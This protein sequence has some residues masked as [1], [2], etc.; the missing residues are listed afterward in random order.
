[1]RLGEVDGQ[2]DLAITLHQRDCERAD[3]DANE[4]NSGNAEWIQSFVAIGVRRVSDT[5]TTPADAAVNEL[6]ACIQAALMADP[7]LSGVDVSPGTV[8]DTQ[9]RSIEPIEPTDGA[10]A[11]WECVF[12]LRPVFPYNCGTVAWL[13][14][15]TTPFT[16]LDDTGAYL[17]D[18]TGAVLSTV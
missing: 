8:I 4:S 10:Y 6:A 16:L 17:I 18:D 12:T 13:D 11:G 15:G 14:N 2:K 9:V 1:V 3:P 7:Q 5:A